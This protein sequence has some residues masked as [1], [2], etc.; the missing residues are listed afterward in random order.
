MYIIEDSK[1]YLE[2]MQAPD[3]Q[4]KII[5]RVKVELGKILKVLSCTLHDFV[6]RKALFG[7][8]GPY[9]CFPLMRV[10]IKYKKGVEIVSKNTIIY[11]RDVIPYVRK[12]LDVVEEIVKAKLVMGESY[13][14]LE[15]IIEK[16]YG[17]SL[18]SIKSAKKRAEIGFNR[19]VTCG[20][21]KGLNFLSWLREESRSF[22]ELNILYRE[23]LIL[24][25]V[26]PVSLF[27]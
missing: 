5:E 20:L 2:K 19:L 22:S 9:F 6:Y 16:K 4:K 13:L 18:N 14:N 1:S 23:R 26:A 21:V 10:K 17:F 8:A 25:G 3:E 12:T 27:R 7:I 24:S 15:G 11:P